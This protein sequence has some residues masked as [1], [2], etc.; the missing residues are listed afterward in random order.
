M[1]GIIKRGGILFTLSSG[2]PGLETFWLSCCM[3]S[4]P[5]VASLPM[6]HW[7]NT[8]QSSQDKGG[9]AAQGLSFFP[10][11]GGPVAGSACQ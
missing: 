11:S 6:F 7:S 9:M 3:L 10:L 4:S 5:L 2:G 1:K 8:F